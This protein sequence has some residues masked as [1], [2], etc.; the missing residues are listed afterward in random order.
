MPDHRAIKVLQENGIETKHR[1]RR[2]KKDD[3]QRFEFI[4]GMDTNNI[5]SMKRFAPK[6]TESK[7]QLLGDYHPD[8]AQIIEDPYYLGGIDGFYA[9][10]DQC[11]KCC[12]A[13]LDKMSK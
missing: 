11:K 7:I 13:F 3:F 6:G 12:E 10:Y 4:F 2:I 9:N 1:A 8:G 5:D